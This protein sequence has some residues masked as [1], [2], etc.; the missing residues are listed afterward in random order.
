[1]SAPAERCDIDRLLDVVDE[2]CRDGENQWKALCPVCRGWIAVG[3]RNKPLIFCFGSC[4]PT[5][6][7]DGRPDSVADQVLRAVGLRM[8]QVYG[9]DGSAAWTY[10]TPCARN[11]VITRPARRLPTAESIARWASRLRS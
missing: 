10:A 3:W 8:Y 7:Q 9:N 2:V 11:S 4:T 5:T 6:D 1:M